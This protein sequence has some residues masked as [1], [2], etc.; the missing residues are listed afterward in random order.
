MS[1]YQDLSEQAKRDA[2]YTFYTAK[3]AERQA[4]NDAD[5]DFVFCPH[6]DLAWA[7][8]NRRSIRRL[9]RGHDLIAEFKSA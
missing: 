1:N 5:D 4:Q 3:F 8:V 9:M 7:E 6:T 2:D